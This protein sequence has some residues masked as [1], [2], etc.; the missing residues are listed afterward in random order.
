M[1]KKLQ[2]ILPLLCFFGIGFTSI[3]AYSQQLRVSP[4]V[5]ERQA[6]SGQA[7]G[8][9]DVANNSDQPFRARVSLKPFTYIREGLKVLESSSNDLTPYLTFSPRE[10]VIAP[11]QTRSI[12]FNARL[13]PSLPQGEYRAMFSVEQLQEKNDPNAK[14]QVSI[15]VSIGAIIF[16]RNG[17]LTPSLNV[18]K[19]FYDGKTQEIKLLVQNTG[20]ATTRA[21]T[22]WNLTENGKPVNSGK[23]EES[24]IIAEGDRYITIAYPPQG[25]TFTPGNYNFSG[26]LTWDFPNKGGNL[27]F[28]VNFTVSPEDIKTETQP[29]QPVKK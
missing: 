9:I 14:N 13:L 12:R 22:E 21:R 7:R 4:L 5:I 1:L 6:A 15:D 28:N 16:V 17:D 20:K 19:A 2:N 23:L 18:E 27:P 24:T 29:A 3:P 10:L 11:G 25:Q 8:V 26:K